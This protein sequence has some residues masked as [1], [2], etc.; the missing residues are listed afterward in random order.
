MALTKKVMG[1]VAAIALVLTTVLTFAFKADKNVNNKAGKTL[2]SLWYEYD[3]VGPR[4]SASSYNIVAT[5]PS[6]DG[7]ASE[8]CPETG[9]VCLIKAPEGTSGHP[10]TFSPTLQTEINTAVSSDTETANVKLRA[11]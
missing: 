7:E 4:T 8:F 5:Q 1:V 9:E 3:N 11:D 6:N 2:A 10:A